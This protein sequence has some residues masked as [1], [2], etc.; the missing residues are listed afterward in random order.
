M[1][2]AGI[3][4]TRKEV[5]RALYKLSN[6]AYVLALVDSATKIMAQ[7]TLNRNMLLH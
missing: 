7:E 4:E 6:G 1:L 5:G 3:I 2:A